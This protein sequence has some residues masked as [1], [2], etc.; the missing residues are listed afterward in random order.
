MRLKI[1]PPLGVHLP[2]KRACDQKKGQRGMFRCCF[3][4]LPPEPQLF[5][6]PVGPAQGRRQSA[7]APTQAATPLLPTPSEIIR[8]PKTPCGVMQAH[9]SACLKRSLVRLGQNTPQNTRSSIST[10]LTGLRPTHSLQI[11][12]GSCTLR[13]LGAKCSIDSTA[14]ANHRCQTQV[15]GQPSEGQAA[16]LQSRRDT[17]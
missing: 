12:T 4:D 1:A 10:L 13:V 9:R 15:T 8:S 16:R 7:L 2:K 3:D 5:G 17:Q 14:Q 11:S 6:G